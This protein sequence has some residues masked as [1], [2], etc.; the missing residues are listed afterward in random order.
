MTKAIAAEVARQMKQTAYGQRKKVTLRANLAFLKQDAGKGGMPCDTVRLPITQAI[1]VMTGIVDVRRRESNKVRVSGFNVRMSMLTKCEVRLMVLVFEPH[2]SIVEHLQQSPLDFQPPS[3]DSRVSEKFT[4]LYRSH[5]SCGLIS[6]H[7]PLRVMKDANRLVLDS[8]DKS[9]YESRLAAHE[10]K[11]LAQFKQTYPSTETLVT[12]NE[13]FKLD[14][15]YSYTY[16]GGAQTNFNRDLEAL[17]VV[18][19]PT[20][21]SEKTTEAMSHVMKGLIIDVYWQDMD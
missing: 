4:S 7:G 18:D 13:Y 2:D 17:L 12:V 20:L 5:S 9:V 8:V 11:P 19:F 15:K 21:P 1:P 14:R 3:D 16:E 10:G 6:E